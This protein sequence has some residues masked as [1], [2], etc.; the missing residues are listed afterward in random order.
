LREENVISLYTPELLFR[1][2]QL[3]VNELGEK[4]SKISGTADKVTE[5]LTSRMKDLMKE[6]ESGKDVANRAEVGLADVRIEFAK[7]PRTQFSEELMHDVERS[8]K[9]FNHQIKTHQQTN[10]DRL[11]RLIAVE[12]DLHQLK[13]TAQFLSSKKSTA[14]VQLQRELA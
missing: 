14:D 3:Q 12:A 4:V 1:Y 2:L 5:S 10:E 13:A 8:M 9:Q 11:R 6:V 7:I